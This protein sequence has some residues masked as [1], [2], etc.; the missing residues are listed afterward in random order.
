[1]VSLSTTTALEDLL[2]QWSWMPFIWQVD[3]H[4]Q[5]FPVSLSLSFS[6]YL[7]VS[8]SPLQYEIVHYLLSGLIG[9]LT[10]CC[11]WQREQERRWMNMDESESE[12]PRVRKSETGGGSCTGWLR[13]RV[14]MG[15][16]GKSFQEHKWLRAGWQN[17][18]WLW[19]KK[20]NRPVMAAAFFPDGLLS[21]PLYS[22]LTVIAHQPNYPLSLAPLPAYGNANCKEKCFPFFK[23]RRR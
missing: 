10:P 14:K 7:S 9:V 18:E 19:G 20:E 23:S 12:L 21:I 2:H 15:G 1:M 3:L 22:S 13:G 17:D 5:C 8:L 16:Q 6:L 4:K 11:G